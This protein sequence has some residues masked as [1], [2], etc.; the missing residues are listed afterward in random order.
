MNAEQVRYT[1]RLVAARDPRCWI[2]WSEGYDGL[3]NMDS[4]DIIPE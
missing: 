1:R 2:V 4:A 3:V